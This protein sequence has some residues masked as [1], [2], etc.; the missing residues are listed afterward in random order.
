MRE[1]NQVSIIPW[2]SKFKINLLG[3]TAIGYFGVRPLAAAFLDC[4]K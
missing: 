4:E 3:Y 1:L 2:A